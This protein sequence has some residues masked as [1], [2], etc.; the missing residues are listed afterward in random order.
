[1]RERTKIVIG[2]GTFK[3]P[4]MLLQCLQSL[5]AQQIPDQVELMMIVV[6]NDKE[7]S[8]EQTY[9]SISQDFPYSTQYFV[10]SEKGIVSMRNR[11]I[12]ECIKENAHYL[13]FL[14][15]DEVA[16]P[17]WILKHLESME[18][19]KADVTAGY[20][21]Q[22]LPDDTPVHM[23]KFYKL[24]SHPTGTDR[25]SGSTRNIMF[26]LEL[27]T[28]HGLRFNPALNL[29]GSSDTFF[30]EEAYKLGAKI[31]WVQEAMVYEEMPKSRITKTWLWNRAY[32]HG[33]S[34]VVRTQIREGRVRAF[35]LLPAAVFK[36]F[37]GAF[38]WLIFGL[39][40]KAHRIG[41]VKRM[42]NAF[43]MLSALFGK[44]YYEYQSTHGH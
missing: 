7:G 1:M 3:R 36:L 39:M 14:D 2:L 24:A 44:K 31:V 40:G 21:E 19:Y 18:Q 22:L 20:V 38:E 33:N 8:A 34:L 41:K 37:I 32:R 11:I 25:I 35:R 17:D 5:K 15:D 12:D 6:D 42:K 9:D 16:E 43:G 23:K 27:C 4:K 28:K 26:S 13:A 30:F 29:T 10:H